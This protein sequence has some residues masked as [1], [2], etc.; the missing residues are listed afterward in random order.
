MTTKNSS[1][2]RRQVLLAA[3]AAGATASGAQAQQPPLKIGAINP[4]SGPLATYGEECARG[5]QMAA[6]EA[7]AKGG[8]LGRRVEVVKG[9]ATNPQQAIA[10]VDQMATR[11]NVEVFIG[12]YSSALAAAGSDAA[13]RHNKVWWDTQALA[14]ELTERKLPNF[15]R[16]GPYAVSFGQTGVRGVVELIA[17]ALKKTPQQTT[18]WL[19]HEESIY[20]KSVVDAQ[21]AA[22]ESAGVK[23]LGIS[24]HNARAADVTDSILRAKR[25]RPDVWMQT[26]YVPDTN[27]LLKTAR[28]QAFRPPAILLT[29]TGD[30][31]ETA[32]AA[33]DFIEGVMVVAYAWPDVSERYSPGMAA[34]LAAYRKAYN[35]DPIA[36]QTMTAYGGMRMMLEV[37][38]AAGSTDPAK[39][40][41]AAQA[42][43]KP[44]NTYPGGYGAKFDDKMQ[45]T[46]AFPTII[47]WQSKKQ[48]TVFPLEARRAGVNLVNVPSKV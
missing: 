13:L 28:E 8:V 46:R 38:Q 19:E 29:G 41:A 9:D 20:G 34:F 36:P 10:G 35:R 33:G 3:V 42:L 11:E 23:V 5:Y 2:T 39:M 25:A 40:R 21:K 27:L 18:V 47:Q 37:I 16:S 48:V 14:A 30:T 1:A 31:S 45:N 22:F 32:E 24:A 12:T 17:P 15:I 7:N 26:G 6:E 43:D 44:Y 4:Y